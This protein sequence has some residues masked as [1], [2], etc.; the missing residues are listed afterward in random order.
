MVAEAERPSGEAPSPYELFAPYYDAIYSQ[1]GKDYEHEAEEIASLIRARNPRARTLLDVGCGTGAHLEHLSRTFAT[2]GLDP[3]PAMLAVAR[4]R[5]P[6][7]LL[8]QG[9][10]S[11]PDMGGEYD[12]IICLF[13]S[14]AYN[15]TLER[16]DDSL[17]NLAA[18]LRPGGVLIVDA[19]FAPDEWKP[20]YVAVDMSPLEGGG[21]VVRVNHSGE[22]DGCSVLSWHFVVATPSEGI[23]WFEE[24][25]LLGLFNRSE[26]VEAL[27]RAGL[28]VEVLDKGAE[29]RDR[30]VAIR[31]TQTP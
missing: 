6:E 16:L 5:L 4:K 2:T 21:R 27:H 17:M 24:R 23:R 31:P 9:E 25:H 13:S 3:S 22:E 15:R 29:D 11:S 7:V 30:I 1:R 26:Y 10:S 14:V 28:R 8:L 19:W 18:H 20:G 12:A